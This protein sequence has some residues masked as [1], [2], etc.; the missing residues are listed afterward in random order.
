VPVIKDKSTIRGPESGVADTSKPE[1][2]SANLKN[3]K[4]AARLLGRAAKRAFDI[5]VAITGLILFSPIYLLSSLAI[6]LDSRG[7]IVSCQVRHGYGNETFRVFKFRSTTTENI[8]GAVHAARKGACVT[9]VSRIVRS[10]GIDGLPQ[11]MN[12]L[13]A[14]V[15]IVGPEPFLTA[16]ESI[17]EDQISSHLQQNKVKAGITGWAQVNGYWEGSNSFEVARRRIEHDLYYIKHQSFLLDMNPDDPVLEK[18]I[19][20]HRVLE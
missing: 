6:K 11:L 13:R 16:P 5:V 7:P 1:V 10:S 17:L 20:N 4:A 15:S 19:R 18:N 14:E 8:E 12:V 2:D 9:G 3:D